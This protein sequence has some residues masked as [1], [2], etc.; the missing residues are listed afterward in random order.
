MDLELSTFR[1]KVCQNII[2]INVWTK[3]IKYKEILYAY[4]YNIM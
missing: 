4:A 1:V 2:I 3:M